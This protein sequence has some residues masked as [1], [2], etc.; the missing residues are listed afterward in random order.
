MGRLLTDIARARRELVER[1][2][3]SEATTPRPLRRNAFDNADSD[4]PIRTLVEKVADRSSAVTDD[5]V[6]AA[7]AS[8]L[9]EDHIFELIVCAA[10]G[11]ADRQ[12]EAA[13]AALAEA[14]GEHR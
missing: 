13:M 12:Y 2:L 14:T 1:V 8:G 6:A 5:D 7:R 11:A 3:D 9:S 10:V 4:D